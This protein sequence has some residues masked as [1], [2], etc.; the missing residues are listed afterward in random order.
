M[1]N[2]FLIPSQQVYRAMYDYA[3]ADDDEVSFNEGDEIIN[4]TII[5]HGWMTGTVVKTGEHGMLPSNYVELV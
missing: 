1:Y 5:D 2:L 4:V 3:A